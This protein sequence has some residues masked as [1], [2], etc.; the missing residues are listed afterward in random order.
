MASI[1]F[2][3][4]F[5][6]SGNRWLKK[7][8]GP[9]DW[10]LRPPTNNPFFTAE[11]LPAI[12]QYLKPH[13]LQQLSAVTFET[14]VSKV[15]GNLQ[16]VRTGMRYLGI[17]LDFSQASIFDKDNS[18][19]NL[20]LSPDQI[21][22]S[23]AIATPLELIEG[24]TVAL[25]DVKGEK[26]LFQV[27][28][29]VKEKG[30]SGYRGSSSTEGTLLI[31]LSTARLLAGIP[32]HAITSILTGMIDNSLKNTEPS[33]FPSPSP[34][35]EVR[36]QKQSDFNQVQ[37]MKKKH[38]FTFV[39]CSLTAVMAGAL[40]M[41]QILLMLADARKETTAVLRAIGF[42][43]RQTETIF[44]IEALLINLLSTGI[45]LVLG[46]P[47]GCG[48]IVL[49]EWLNRDLIF[50]Y[51][52]H[53]VPITP[54]ISLWSILVTGIIILCLLMLTSVIA[55]YK[56]GNLKI[57]SAL[58]GDANKVEPRMAFRHVKI[59]IGLTLCSAVI[60][61]IHIVQLVT[62][63]GIA[64]IIGEGDSSLIQSLSVLVLWFVSSLSSLYIVVQIL[65]FIQKLLKP[66]LQRLGIGEAAQILAFRYPAGNY[67]RTFVVTLL[68]SCCFMLLTLVVIITQHNYRNIEQKPY[69]V[70][71]Y[72]A[73]IKYGTD[74]EKQRILS[75]LNQDQELGGI[76]QN[77]SIME[78][79]MIQTASNGAILAKSQLN[80]TSPSDAFLSGGTP[81]LSERSANFASDEEAWK[82]VMSNPQYVILD[83]K[84]SY[85]PEE[86]PSVYG[87]GKQISRKL[88][89]GEHLKLDVYEKPAGP[90]TPGF[91]KEPRTVDSIDI[92][93]IGFADTSTGLEFYNVMFVHPHIYDKLKAQGYRWETTPEK[94]YI[95]LPLLSKETSYLRKI[96][97]HVVTLGINGF[98]APGISEASED[99]S[100][101]QML[102]VFNGFMILAMG[103]GL[104]GLAILQ[105]R[106]VKERSKTIAMLRCIGLSTRFVRQ[107]L[108]LEGTMIG[109]TGLLNGC[110]FGSTG[111]YMIVKLLESTKKP[112]D[113]ALSFYYPW[114]FVLPIACTLMLLTL[115]LNLEPS[116][117]ILRLSPSEAVRSAD[118]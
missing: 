78:P 96:E 84:Y 108:L 45:G 59:R 9:I 73:Y 22:L 37:Q 65:P 87:M 25:T 21:V 39:L 48:I 80:L 91:G 72:P 3:Q 14:R 85:A 76:T 63:K 118:E 55:C 31:G 95:M 30:I 110:L 60:L 47:L 107:M 77:S 105:F 94:G 90:N 6:E 82:A 5:D 115:L 81:K 50:A 111:G 18:L 26:H 61:G 83:K 32:D 66:L 51:S 102:W 44:F 112:T 43:R 29:I 54:Y 7:H 10:E 92:Q 46:I 68:F 56:L 17:G 114:E 89:V 23:D 1:V 53:T 24:D 69:T 36:E 12:E 100:T 62:G 16:S 75:I 27:K 58:R 116:E 109:W 13:K 49:F 52:A 20:S 38:G 93:I 99:I 64:I 28:K 88:I 42:Q 71:G 98:T 104:A 41:I 11:E 19:W 97:E 40:L 106:A 70:L 101:I 117:R 15:D 8:Y 74:S 103:I 35:F 113:P 33:H 67:R 4:S 34:L 57:V 79:Y 86:W 2:F